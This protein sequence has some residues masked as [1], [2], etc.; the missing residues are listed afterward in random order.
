[1]R[2]I[3]SLENHI[4]DTPPVLPLCISMTGTIRIRDIEVRAGEKKTGFLKISE[5][6]VGSLDMPIAIV[7]GKKDGPALCLTAGAHPCEYSGI[8]AVI[9]IIKETSPDGLSG[10]ILGVPVLNMA[11]FSSRIARD[12]AAGAGP[13]PS[14]THIARPNPIDNI[15]VS[16]V[17]PGRVDGTVTERMVYVLVNEILKKCDMRIDCHGGDHDERVNP[18]TY[19]SRIGDEKHDRKVESMARIYGFRYIIERDAAS[20]GSTT[21]IAPGIIA[22]CGGIKVLLESDINQHVEGIRNVMKFFKMIEGKPRIRVKQFLVKGFFL[23]KA[24]RGGLFYPVVEVGDS[25]KKGQ[26]VGEI[27]NLWGD[28]TETLVSPGDGVVR[29]IRTNHAAYTG[30]VLMQIMQSPEPAPPFP[31]TDPF[32]ELAEYEQISKVFI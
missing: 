28:V 32:I 3:E 19:F 29:I 6:P 25:V 31:P 23:V 8:A 13:G 11:G 9:R 18:N 4:T 21:T 22:E 5:T 2:H 7:N 26:K 12:S 30:D 1:L 15:N 20:S 27:W 10:A 14:S 24:N 16:R 17:F